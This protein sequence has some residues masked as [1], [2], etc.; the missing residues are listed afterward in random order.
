MGH[1][2]PAFSGS[3]TERPQ[4]E[5]LF[6]RDVLPQFFMP[7]FSS[8]LVLVAACLISSSPAQDVHLNEAGSGVILSRSAFVHGYRHGYEEGYHHG[9]VD[10]NMG[11]LP[12][13]QQKGQFR[14]LKLK[15]SYMPS[16]GAKRSFEDGFA[17][18]LR[19]GYA[20]GYSGRTFR[21]VES[22][23]LMAVEIASTPPSED[24]GGIYFDQG[25]TAGYQDGWQ[26]G[27]TS[28]SSS[29]EPMDMRHVNCGSF[30][31]ENDHDR[32]AQDS[33]CE[34]Y[35]RGY[36]LG[37]TDIQVLRRDSIFLEASK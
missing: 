33:Y 13:S 16:F 32:P 2:Y 29:A 24:P 18:G 11:R 7:R 1:V 35:R 23:R 20:D 14:A 8:F 5:R 4:E 6:W 9:N 34:G 25:L 36:Y 31:P 10:I 22:L 19:A 27:A 3:K 17:A 21:A 30:H 37:R 26:H 15:S 28:Q 12:R